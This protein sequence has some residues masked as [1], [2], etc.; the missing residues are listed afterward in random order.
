[1]DKGYGNISENKK[2]LQE[3]LANGRA[4]DNIW[5]EKINEKDV[6]PRILSL[7]EFQKNITLKTHVE[8]K[9]AS[10][11]IIASISPEI[12]KSATQEQKA[13]LIQSYQEQMGVMP[14]ESPKSR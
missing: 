7:E 1:M 2:K 12:W 14:E 4:I 11:Q 3:E 8:K 6:P 5:I 9:S 10:S 13:I